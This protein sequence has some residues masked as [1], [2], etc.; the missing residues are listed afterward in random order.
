MKEKIKRMIADKEAKLQ[1][2]RRKSEASESVEELRSLGKDID[3]IIAELNNLKEMYAEVDEPAGGE[4]GAGEEGARSGNKK[5]IT[6]ARSAAGA[7]EG[8]EAEKRAA[9]FA[10]SGRMNISNKEARA[11]LVPSGKIATPTEVDGITEK[12]NNVSSIID[13]VKVTNADKMGAYNVA[14]EDT[15]AEAAATAEGAAYNESDPTFGFV[16]IKP[17]KVTVISYIS[18]EV[19]NQSPLDYEG[20]V[21][22]AALNALRKKTAG[23]VSAKL[24]ES[25]IN[26]T[27]VISAIDAGTLRKIALYYGGDENIVGGAVLNL[28]KKDLV[29]F[30]DVR[31]TNEKKAVYE[32]TPD[33]N[34]PNTGVIKD[35]GLSVKYCINSNCT[36]LSEA[37]TEADAKTMFYGS[38][39]DAFELAL[40]TDYNVKV[41]EDFKFDKGLLT[42]RG[43]VSVGGAV[44]KKHGFVVVKKGA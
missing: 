9:K 35:G 11:V 2:L 30:G 27:L 21:K 7:G 41:S 20:K 25:E 19:R 44:I 4:G 12:F 26:E 39:S 6:N 24:L 8:E 33:T 1:E 10:E 29:A 5:P 36:A 14:Y 34:N 28:N 38:C 43:D 37:T 32:I 16:E 22:A 18:D 17:E 13:M 31:G 40:F 23:I 15:D 42:I 3:A